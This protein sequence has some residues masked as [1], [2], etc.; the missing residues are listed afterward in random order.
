M[1]SLWDQEIEVDNTPV[2]EQFFNTV[3]K[4]MLDVG[5]LYEPYE[6]HKHL[7]EF[8]QIY[9]SE[10]EGLKMV[11]E[12]Y[13][14]ENEHRIMGILLVEGDENPC[15]CFEYDMLDYDDLEKMKRMVDL[16]KTLEND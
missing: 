8:A 14:C 1:D 7:T 5:L 13:V 3:M 4:Q 15:Q 9:G 11:F 2:S 16:A 10:Q 12:V 6:Y